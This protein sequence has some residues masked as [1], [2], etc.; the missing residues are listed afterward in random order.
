VGGGEVFR[1]EVAGRTVRFEVGGL[2]GSGNALAERDTV[3]G[4]DPN[5]WNTWNGAGLVGPDADTI[6]DRAT[7]LWATLT[8]AEF[9][10]RYEGMDDCALWTGEEVLGIGCDDACVAIGKRCGDAAQADC[11]AIC[12]ELPRTQVDCL[13]LDD[14]CDPESCAIEA[15]AID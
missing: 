8:V 5:V 10:D 3:Y 11:D 13:R 7:A 1:R 4:P 15:E 2:W 6:L 14:T 12:P 9:L